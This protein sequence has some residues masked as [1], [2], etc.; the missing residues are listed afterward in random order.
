MSRP[1]GRKPIPETDYRASRWMRVLGNP[2]AYEI[3]KALGTRRVAVTELAIELQQSLDSLSH[4]LRHLRHVDIVRYET[5][6]R[7]KIYWLKEPR[8]LAILRQIE[9]MVER[10]RVKTW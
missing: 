8:L 9:R 5:R 10:M 3:V 6:G 4:T 7:N 2:L 1:E